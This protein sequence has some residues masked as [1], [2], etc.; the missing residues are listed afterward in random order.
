MVADLTR[1]VP[2]YALLRRRSPPR[3]LACR[4]NAAVQRS[5]DCAGHRWCRHGRVFLVG[6]E[7]YRKSLLPTFF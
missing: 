5:H 1:V 4:E 6:S 2:L 7:P 3:R